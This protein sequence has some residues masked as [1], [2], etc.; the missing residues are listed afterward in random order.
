M[1]NSKLTHSDKKN[2][3]RIIVWHL[4][5]LSCWIEYAKTQKN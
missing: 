3:N 4:A 1:Q 2:Y 5:S